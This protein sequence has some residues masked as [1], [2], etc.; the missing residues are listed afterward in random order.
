MA[1]E[2]FNYAMF[3]PYILVNQ[4]QGESGAGLMS[5]EK[6]KK[7]SDRDLLKMSSEEYSFE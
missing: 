5:L 4:N 6:G 7:L 2:D 3:N 1:F